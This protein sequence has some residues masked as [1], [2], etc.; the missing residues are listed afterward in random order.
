MSPDNKLRVLYAE[1]DADTRELTCLILANEGF[2]VTC[3]DTPRDFLKTA[4]EEK[5][6]AYMLD[7]WMPEMSGVELCKS[8]RK[9]D[10]RTPIIFYT[11]A[12]FDR[13][14]AEALNSGA[15]AYVIKPAS[16][17]E[18]GKTIR[19]VTK[20]ATAAPLS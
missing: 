3:P 13:D 14:R 12:A 11:A 20:A 10:S 19:S 7:A 18:L 9:F 17:E 8:I 4:K 2:E 5:F 6:D 16:F 15:Q 1:D